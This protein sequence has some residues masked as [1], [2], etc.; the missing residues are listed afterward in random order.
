MPTAWETAMLGRLAAADFPGKEEVAE[1][2]ANCVVMT[3][4][5]DG[6]LLIMPSTG[7]PAPVVKRVPVEAEAVGPD[8]RTLHAELHVLRG[9][10]T[11][12][13]L[14]CEDGSP[15]GAPPEP[16]EWSVTVLPP[17]PPDGWAG[18]PAKPR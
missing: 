1:Q 17:R 14:Y 7:A 6:S 2:V 10:V 4:D 15:V 16:A 8:G 11:E 18:G 12:L 3:A 9:V 5:R 13:D